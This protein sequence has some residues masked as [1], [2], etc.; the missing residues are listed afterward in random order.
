MV[1]VDNKTEIDSSTD[2]PDINDNSSKTDAN[3][4]ANTG[5]GKGFSAFTNNSTNTGF[6]K[7]FSAFTN[8]STNTGYG[9]RRQEISQ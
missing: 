2:T 5:F 1:I 9:T 3:N 8:N 4:A 7:G 6:G